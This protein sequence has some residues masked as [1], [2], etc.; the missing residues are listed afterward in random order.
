MKAIE[1]LFNLPTIDS[2][3]RHKLEKI[4]SDEIFFAPE[5][6][7]STNLLVRVAIFIASRRC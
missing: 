2:R 1:K 5:S 3:A 7:F 4:T 6:G